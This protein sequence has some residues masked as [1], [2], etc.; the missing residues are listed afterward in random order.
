[1]KKN[2]HAT[3]RYM[4]SKQKRPG[5][6]NNTSA[7]EGGGVTRRATDHHDD[8]TLPTHPPVP[9]KNLQ[10]VT[11]RPRAIATL[12]ERTVPS[13]QAGRT[14]PSNRQPGSRDNPEGDPLQCARQA[15][16]PA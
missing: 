2:K 8:P 16:C 4:I 6:P 10:K 12:T 13:R 14:N 11:P 1:M 3:S 15:P 7:E 5:T 9:D